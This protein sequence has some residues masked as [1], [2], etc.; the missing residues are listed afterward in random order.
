MLNTKDV[1]NFLKDNPTLTVVD[2]LNDQ[3]L[4]LQQAGKGGLTPGN[5]VVGRN[6]LEVGEDGTVTDVI[7]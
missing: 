1:N 4:K 5:Y 7:I 3:N 6:I 2:F